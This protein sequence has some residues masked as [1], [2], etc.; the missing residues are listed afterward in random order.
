M[1]KIIFDLSTVWLSGEGM[2]WVI[3]FLRVC[4]SRYARS[5]EVGVWQTNRVK[6][7]MGAFL[8]LIVWSGDAWGS[9]TIRSRCFRGLCNV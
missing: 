4:L 8:D 9:G 7:Q 2:I 1:W 3:D 5:G 6:F